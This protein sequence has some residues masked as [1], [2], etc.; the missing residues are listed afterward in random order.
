MNDA[1]VPAVVPSA[2]HAIA[3]SI[4]RPR[5]VRRQI[6]LVRHVQT[7]SQQTTVWPPRKPPQR[8]PGKLFMLGSAF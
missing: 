8:I 5:S 2:S 7:L 3:D 6:S 1:K 4:T